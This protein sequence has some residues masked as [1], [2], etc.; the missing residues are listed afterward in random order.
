MK[1]TMLAFVAMCVALPAPAVPLRWPEGTLRGFPVV[2]DASGRQI[3]NGTLTQWIEDG[4]LHVTATYDFEDG[5][6][7]EEQTLLQQHPELAQLRWSWE[8]R[9]G[10]EV[11]RSYSIDFT[12]GHAVVHKR[13]E[14]TLDDHLED[15]R[16]L[17][18]A[19]TGVGFMYAV[20]NLVPD[21]EKGGEIELT[22][23]A[24]TPKPRT[25]TVSIRRDQE[26]SLAMGG[27]KLAAE[28]FVIHP[29]IPLA[30]IAKLFVK[31]PDQYLWFYRPAPPAFLRADIP[32]AEPSDP[33]LRIELIGGPRP[34][35]PQSRRPK[36][37]KRH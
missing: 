4:K 6:V 17:G 35:P 30:F 27:R 33:I 36:A 23:V 37:P 15:A 24:F 21:L 16:K 1:A 2:R 22:A 29:Q 7:V 28:R 34:P 3:A 19:F 25:V 5:R 31:A 9:K 14:D 10:T 32:L 20:K 11:Q 18:R 12:T 26:G 13:G 8:E